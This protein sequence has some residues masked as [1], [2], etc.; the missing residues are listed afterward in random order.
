MGRRF[1]FVAWLDSRVSHAAWEY[2]DE[3]ESLKPANCVS[4]GWLI[5]ATQEYLT[6][7]GTVSPDQV[8]HRLTI[9]RCAICEMTEVKYPRLGF[10]CEE[11]KD[12]VG[13]TNDS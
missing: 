12:N 6:L 10:L 2:L 11:D 13:N 3:L 5:E 7:V 9:P 1:L 4:A 8:L